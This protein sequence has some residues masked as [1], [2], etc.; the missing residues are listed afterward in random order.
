MIMTQFITDG[1]IRT[2]DAEKVAFC[3]LINHSDYYF[4]YSPEVFDTIEIENYKSFGIYVDGTEFF[5]VPNHI[6]EIMTYIL[7]ELSQLEE[8]PSEED[9]SKIGSYVSSW[10]TR[11][12][13]KVYQAFVGNSV[14]GKVDGYI[15][16]SR[17][18]D[19]IDINIEMLAR[20]IRLGDM[21][22]EAKETDSTNQ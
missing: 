12:N 7:N 3:S 6:H 1:C 2:V 4:R 10:L 13:E 17:G 18:F 16:P 9:K 20:Q 11:I 15:T 8:N 22:K 5:I 21:A 19:G 14:E